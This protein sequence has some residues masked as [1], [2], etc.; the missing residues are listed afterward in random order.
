MK[1]LITG[2]AGF[3]GYHIAKSLSEQGHTIVGID[4]FNSTIYTNKLKYDRIR[5]L[6]FSNADIDNIKTN[7]EYEII[8]KNG[9][10]TIFYGD[11]SDK[12][13]LEYI[14]KAQQ[15]DE[16][17]DCIIHLA[18]IPNT[19]LTSEYYDQIV[20]T[21][22]NGT[23]NLFECVR[24][25]SKDSKVIYASSSSVYGV[26]V[27]S[28]YAMT[29]QC[30]ENIAEFYANMY[31]IK[32][33]G[34]RPF[35]VYGPYCR[36]DMAI[37]KFTNCIINNLPLQM[38]NN[39]NNSR[40]FTYIDDF[41]KCVNLIIHSDQQ[42]IYT[43]YDVGSTTSTK[44][45]SIVEKLS[46][47]LNKKPYIEMC[48]QNENDVQITNTDMSLFKRDYNYVPDASIDDGLKKYIEWHRSYYNNY[49]KY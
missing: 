7:T 26:H 44:V 16:K 9:N 41:V 10:I 42:N 29:K 1:F 13:T 49:N 46:N 30:D 14:F 27:K 40:A 6:G 20:S 37:H 43:L 39:G 33:I 18:A 24:L 28:L 3:I 36:P 23:Y 2:I 45:S 35:T 17:F 34:I 32:T 38:Y 48:P 8:S 25:Y 47:I 12:E 21:N 15:E 5:Q 4:N 22:I 19:R 11:I 31:N